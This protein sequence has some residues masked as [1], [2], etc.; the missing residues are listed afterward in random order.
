ML[1]VLGTFGIIRTYLVDSDYLSAP[2]AATVRASLGRRGGGA[3]FGAAPTAPGGDGDGAFGA[4]PIAPGGDGGYTK[5][6]K[7]IG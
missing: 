5:R 1:V 3:R 7:L 4:A 2:H 6:S